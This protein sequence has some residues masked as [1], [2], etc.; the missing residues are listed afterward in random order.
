MFWHKL[1]ISASKITF[2]LGKQQPQVTPQQVK[3]L[4]L[5]AAITISMLSKT[6]PEAHQAA[7]C[8]TLA[9]VI[10]RTW[11]TPKDKPQSSASKVPR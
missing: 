3:T 4:I 5:P 11:L 9:T 8:L 1:R 10:N 2:N 6:V 7:T